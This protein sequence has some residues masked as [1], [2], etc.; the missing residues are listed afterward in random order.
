MKK[1]NAP[2]FEFM[3]FT[4]EIAFGRRCNFALKM[5]DCVDLEYK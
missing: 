2:R 3:A 4:N 5:D 1:F